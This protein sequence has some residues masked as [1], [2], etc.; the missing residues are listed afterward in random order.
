[1]LQ[2]S[3]GRIKKQQPTHSVPRQRLNWSEMGRFDK[4]SDSHMQ[5]EVSPTELSCGKI[6]LYVIWSLGGIAGGLEKKGVL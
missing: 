6:E 2:G 4:L 3:Q 5:P 1:M